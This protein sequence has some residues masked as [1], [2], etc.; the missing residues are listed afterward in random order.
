[1]KAIGKVRESIWIIRVICRRRYT[2]IYRESSPPYITESGTFVYNVFT[3]SLARTKEEASPGLFLFCLSRARCLFI[4][5]FPR[6]WE[7]EV[8]TGNS[9]GNLFSSPF[10]F[11]SH[12]LF[13]KFKRPDGRSI[14]GGDSRRSNP[15]VSYCRWFWFVSLSLR[16]C[17]C[18]TSK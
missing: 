16:G 18:S 5:F 17:H 3:Y 13:L 1:M 12:T 11:Y 14:S 4:Y 15:P 2:Y 8:A 10:L 9:T 6:D 7:L